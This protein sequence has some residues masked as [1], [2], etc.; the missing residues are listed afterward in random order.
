L[1]KN[2]GFDQGATPAWADSEV[3]KFVAIRR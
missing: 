1:C 3:H 2:N